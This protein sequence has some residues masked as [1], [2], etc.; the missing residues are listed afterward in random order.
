MRLDDFDYALPSDLIAQEPANPRDSSRLMVVDRKDGR[1]EHRTFNEIGEFLAAGDLLTVNDTRVV[2]A[3]LRGRRARSGGAVEI[4]L[5]KPAP[6]G[7][8]EALVSPGRRLAPG[9]VVEVGKAR[10]PLEIGE[11]LP[12]GRRLV[13]TLGGDA[14]P[15]LLRDLGE[16]PL[17]PYIRR[18]LV[19]PERYQTVYA[20]EEGAV[21]APTAGLHFTARLL[22]SLKA[23][24]VGVVPITLHVGPGT[25]RSVSA[26]HVAD[27]RMEAEQFTISAE[28][29]AAI[30]GRQGALVAVGTTVVRALESASSEDGRVA[31]CSGW[32]DLYVLP[33]YR[34]RAVEAMVTN[35]HLPR[36]TLIML[37]AAFAG[38]ELVM[39]AYREAVRA[40]YRF[41]SFGDAMLIR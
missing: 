18:P 41:Y 27:H 16:M 10:V 12:E 1:I 23:G 33:G 13:R 9:S 11:R 4:L 7:A 2:P 17:P 6:D 32:T 22:G 40:R 39:E 15:E 20:R 34:F 29:A 5:V 37:V 35:F 31:S 30:N 8:W 28:T 19:D 38:R 36:T 24:G 21:A 26:E 25:F 14:I 3:R